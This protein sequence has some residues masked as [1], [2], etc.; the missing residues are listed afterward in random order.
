AYRFKN[1]LVRDAAYRATAKKIRA[2]LHER[3]AD[4]LEQVAGGRVGEYQEIIGYH[5]EQAYRYR[6]ELG[7]VDDHA[8]ALAARAARHL[9][10]AGLRANDR[11]DVRGAAN[12]LGRASALP[13]PDSAERL[14]FLRHLAYAVDQTGRMLEARA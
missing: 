11:A 6:E 2:S 8:R 14:E 7:A 10:A 5:L 1:I 4:W 3:F 13:P 12:L 9:G